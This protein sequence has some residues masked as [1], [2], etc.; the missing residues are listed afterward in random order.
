[1]D[2]IQNLFKETIAEFMENGL[3]AELDE[4]LGYS[5]YDYRSKENDN[6]CNEHSSKKL[7]TS[8]GDVD[9]SSPRDRKGEFEPQLLKKDQTS[10]SQECGS[11]IGYADLTE[12]YWKRHY[13]RY[14]FPLE[15]AQIAEINRAESDM[16][17]ALVFAAHK[18]SDEEI[19]LVLQSGGSDPGSRMRIA[20]EFSKGKS[21]AELAAFLQKEYRGGKGLVTGQGKV[22]VW[23]GWR[24]ACAR[25]RRPVRFFRA[26]C[27]LGRCGTAHRRAAGA[28]HVRHHG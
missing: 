14:F 27:S 11:P 5:R 23:C 28:G 1:M 6:S 24:A 3:E 8:F 19:D 18:F 15:A 4:E 22:S 2:D 13:Y 7:K 17:S 16:P 12:S 10:I 21:K 20:T 25:R 26:A 9:V